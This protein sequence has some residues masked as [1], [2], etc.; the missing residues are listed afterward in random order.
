MSDCEDERMIFQELLME[1]LY[2][3]NDVSIIRKQ[4]SAYTQDPVLGNW[5]INQDSDMLEVAARMVQHWG[6]K[7]SLMNE[8][9]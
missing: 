1:T 4:F 3:H 9:G 7:A 5:L 2:T 8:N 6:K